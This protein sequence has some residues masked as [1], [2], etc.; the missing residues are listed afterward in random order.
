[1]FA[2][3]APRYDLLNQVLSLG[4]HHRWRRVAAR[5]ASVPPGGSALDVC[6]GTGDLAREL[7]RWAGAGGRVVGADFCEA[8]VR[9][10][11]RKLARVERRSEGSIRLLVSD[12]QRLPVADGAFDAATIAFGIRNVQDPVRVF[13]EMVRAVRGGGAVVCLEFGLPDDRLRRRLI[14]AYERAVVPVLGGLLSRRSAYSYLNRSIAGFAAPEEV[15]EMMRKVGLVS[16]A[17]VAMN[18]GSVYA[19]RGVK[20]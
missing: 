8:M 16:V 19:H 4:R 1:M 7:L 14:E 15:R 9:L 20:P 3:I 2:Q 17:S 6:T 11:R 13:L 10:G 18:L 12:A 5:L